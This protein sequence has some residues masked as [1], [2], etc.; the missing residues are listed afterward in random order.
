MTEKKDDFDTF[1]EKLQQEIIEKETEDFNAYIVKLCHN[2]PNW[3]KP[4]EGKVTFSHSAPDQH[5]NL[6]EFFLK[7]ESDKVIK[8][9]FITDG[10]GATVAV[11][12]QITLLIEGKSLD[13]S[14]KLTPEDVIKA[15]H[16]LPESHKHCAEL[17]VRILKELIEKY[18]NSS[19]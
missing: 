13:Y 7:I 3:G 5:G 19:H 8:A 9:N 6:I 2:P 17:T 12:S 10:C 14:Y 11:A 16:R 1:V 4:P 15:L 18:K